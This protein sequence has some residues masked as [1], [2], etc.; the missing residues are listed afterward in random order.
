MYKCLLNIKQFPGYKEQSVK[1][2]LEKWFFL[3]LFQTHIH[4]TE[5][6]GSEMN[7]YSAYRNHCVLE[8]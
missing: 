8:S 4:S 6:C 5:K 3:E 7:P 1:F 2:V